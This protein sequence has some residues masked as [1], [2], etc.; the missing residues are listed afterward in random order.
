MGSIDNQCKTSNEDEEFLYAM[1]LSS[2]SVLPVAMQV[3]VEL[4][5][6]EIIGKAGPN[7]Q[8]SPKEI[9]SHLPV[10]KNPNA[11]NMLDR[12]LRLLTSYSILTSS[13]AT[14]KDGH[15][16]RLYG[17]APVCKYFVQNEDGVSM[18]PL[19]LFSQDKVLME[20]RCYLKDAILEGGIAFNKAH[21]MH[22]FEYGK[23]DARFDQLFNRGMFNYSTIFVKKML[24]TYEGFEDLKEVVDVGGGVGTTIS[25]ITSKYTAIHGINFDLPHVIEQAQTYPGVVHIGGNMFDSV[26]KG[27]TM[28]MK[29]ILHDWSDENCVNILKN[30]YKA[31]PDDGKVI[32]VEAILPVAPETNT[33]AKVFCQSDLIMMSTNPGGKERTEEEFHNLAKEAGFVCMKKVVCICNMSWVI[34]FYKK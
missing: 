34:E 30:C 29:W 13:L 21:G 28:F 15:T 18:C 33:A 25:L 26:P 5:L 22:A 16:E 7:A 4:E 14:D 10:T 20:S 19:L 27:E 23:T 8:L 24:E 2:A 3:A 12:I 32:I 9:A 11:H 1:Q 31:L 17:L 6:F